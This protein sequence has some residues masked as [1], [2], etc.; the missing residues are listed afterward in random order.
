MLEIICGFLYQHKQPLALHAYCSNYTDLSTPVHSP[1]TG[2]GCRAM[3]T[4]LVQSLD[5]NRDSGMRGMAGIMGIAETGELQRSLH[6]L[7][8]CRFM[9]MQP[10]CR[11]HGT[12]SQSI[13]VGFLPRF[14]YCCCSTRYGFLRSVSVHFTLC[15]IANL[16]GSRWKTDKAMKM[17]AG[18]CRP[19]VSRPVREH[20]MLFKANFGHNLLLMNAPLRP[21]RLPQIFTDF[22]RFSKQIAPTNEVRQ[23]HNVRPLAA[24]MLTC[25]LV[26]VSAPAGSDLY[27]FGSTLLYIHMANTSHSV[28]QPA[29][30]E[31]ATNLHINYSHQQLQIRVVGGGVGVPPVGHPGGSLM[32]KTS[33]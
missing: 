5:T 18:V 23:P 30:C 10:A 28:D 13:V 24:A 27:S 1:I 15:Q 2:Y 11:F 19:A 31:P 33:W 26:K 21:A 6:L 7:Y 9:I 8:T 16:T 12:Y 14:G 3:L 22:Y 4:F 20:K 25:W 29:S 32:F 17:R